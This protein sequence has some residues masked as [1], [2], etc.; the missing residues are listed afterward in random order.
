MM[1]DDGE[2]RMAAVMAERALG[3]PKGSNERDY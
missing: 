2:R 3:S 1:I